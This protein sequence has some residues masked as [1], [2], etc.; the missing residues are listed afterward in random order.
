MTSQTELKICHLSYSTLRHMQQNNVPMKCVIV[1]AGVSV[2]AKWRE[3]EI[4]IQNAG[5]RTSLVNIHR[6]KTV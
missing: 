1:D 6:P 5:I 3:D 2:D 4:W